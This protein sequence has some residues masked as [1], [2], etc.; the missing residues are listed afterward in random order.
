MS[1]S[2]DEDAQQYRLPEPPPKIDS[3][4]P[5]EGKA[6]KVEPVT[7]SPESQDQRVEG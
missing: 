3:R 4:P 6:E 2:S 5:A 7:V 1:E